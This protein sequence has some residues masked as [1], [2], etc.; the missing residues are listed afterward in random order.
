MKK[1]SPLSIY[2]CL[3]LGA[4]VLSACAPAGGAD[5]RP[6][7]SGIELSPETMPE[8]A[9]IQVPMPASPEPRPNHRAE[10]SSLWQ[11]GSDSFF[12]DRRASNVGDVVTI[13]IEIDDQAR[14]RN[15][16]SRSRE[17]SASLARPEFL[18]YG[19]KIDRIL[20]GID[21]GEVPENLIELGA[22]FERSGA[23][24]INRGEN[25]NLKLA[26]LVIDRLPNGNLV[27]A[28]RQEVKV[29]DE[30]RELRV[31]GI[32]DPRDIAMDN[33]IDYAKIAEAR[34]TYG[35]RGQLSRQTRTA[36]GEEA[37]DILLPY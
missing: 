6:E 21:E 19:A 20:P 13:D 7:I 30:I 36:Y 11:S 2:A 26:A 31:A 5:R 33:S 22:G 18:G 14:M 3:L 37:M 32:I 28:G 8:A 23:G 1:S 10:G 15:E 35:G 9:R 34:I 4:A 25:I 17:G 16:S 29:N 24:S 12:A 27:V